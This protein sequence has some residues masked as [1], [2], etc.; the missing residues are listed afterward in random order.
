MSSVLWS[1]MD[2]DCIAGNIIL[3]VIVRKI[4]FF[5]S[6]I[7]LVNFHPWLDDYRSFGLLDSVLDCF[8]AEWGSEVILLELDVSVVPL[9]RTK[10]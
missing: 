8:N 6:L 4:A 1:L 10:V 7:P 3:G 5:F 9:G 2:D